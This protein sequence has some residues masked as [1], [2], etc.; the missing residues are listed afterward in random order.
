MGPRYDEAGLPAAE[1]KAYM[2]SM[3][4][5]GSH[6]V[7]GSFAGDDSAVKTLKRVFERLGLST[8]QLVALCGAHYIARWGRE[9]STDPELFDKHY[10][11]L[12][13]RFSNAYFRQVST[14]LS[15]FMAWSL[16][17]RHEVTF[18]VLDT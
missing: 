16:A 17:S 2:S 3:T 18:D 13:K 1:G 12:N 9:T 4:C 6:S 7:K 10:R 5:M 15:C 11:D 14:L 8:Q